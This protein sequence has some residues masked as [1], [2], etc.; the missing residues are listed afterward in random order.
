MW[1]IIR[2]CQKE[3]NLICSCLRIDGESLYILLRVFVVFAE[4]I[5]PA[6]MC[7]NILPVHRLSTPN[8]VTLFPDTLSSSAVPQPDSVLIGVEHE[9]EEQNIKFACHL[10]AIETPVTRPHTCQCGQAGRRAGM[11]R[12]STLY[13]CYFRWFRAKS[14][15]IEEEESVKIADSNWNSKAARC[16]RRFRY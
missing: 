11:W 16:R 9:Q 4:P 6:L 7:N 5:S 13:C 10:I 12:V 2:K 15:W 3:L 14:V 1:I 8:Y